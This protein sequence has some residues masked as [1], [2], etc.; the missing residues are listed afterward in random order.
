MAFTGSIP[1]ELDEP[2]GVYFGGVSVSNKSSAPSVSRSTCSSHCP[3]TFPITPEWTTYQSRLPSFRMLNGAS[4]LRRRSR[5]GIRK[6]AKSRRSAAMGPNR[7]PFRGSPFGRAACGTSTKPLI[8]ARRIDTGRRL[9]PCR[10][11][12]GTGRSNEA[13]AE[14]PRFIRLADETVRRPPRIVDAQVCK[15]N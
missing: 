14:Q 3:P 9:F 6:A 7:S 2:T 1:T 8:A 13:R 11:I 5:G 15:K 10:R 12:K 4:A